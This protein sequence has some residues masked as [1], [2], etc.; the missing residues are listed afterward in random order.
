MIKVFLAEDEFIVREGI[1]KNIDWASHGYD[2]CG[3]ASD[4]ELALPM[5]RKLSPDIVITDI[6]MPF[7]DGLE[8]SRLIRK[9]F[10]WIEIIILS[11]Y[12]EFEYAKEGIKIGV[13]QYLTKPITGEELL[14]EVD[15]V[16]K[17]IVARKEEEALKEQFER[18]MAENDK[19]DQ[20][21]LFHNI[22]SG[23][24]STTD[25]LAM[26]EKL[27]IDLFAMWY[28]I[29]L[30][31]AKSDNHEIDEYSNSSVDISKRI[32]EI[33][34]ENGCLLFDRNLEGAAIV[35]KADSVEELISKQ[36]TVISSIEAVLS[37]YSQVRYFGGIGQPV[38]RLSSIR[39][40]FEDARYAM[41][42]RYFVTDNRFISGEDA[43]NVSS[44][45]TD[46]NLNMKEIDAKRID[47]RNL[48]KFFKTG[49]VDEAPFFLSEFLKSAGDNAIKSGIFRQYI[50]MDAYFC[51]ITFV[52]ELGKS[53]NDIDIPEVD[54]DILASVDST[55]KYMQNI[56]EKVIGVRESI[57]NSRYS[58]IVE[59]AIRYIEDNYS[60]DELSLNMLASHVNVSPNHL[61]TIFSQQ[62]GQTFI[63]Y[64]TEYRME[65]AKELLKCTNMRS[66]EIS[67]E[68]GY[69]DPHY[70]SY[71][72]KK[73]VGMTPTKYRGGKDSEDEE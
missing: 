12:E 15:A 13:A 19:K 51:A 32:K 7:M 56:F 20:R 11:G 29:V 9:E 25:L 36:E 47:R 26:A 50:A 34:D 52:E 61:S 57:A 37:E 24:Y 10:P 21:E 40:S 64:L 27:D 33:I 17:R 63:K 14:A 4:G 43:I 22:V 35:F 38:N 55:I 68:V 62:T 23:G 70:F 46:D 72:F 54:T 69:K 18:E 41:A 67:E 49:S 66:S 3:E 30:L 44:S 5:I 58:E 73:S 28:S 48:V 71:M 2:F 59:A 1:K 31:Y 39:S 65:K 42:H 16:A 6:K 60:D 53:R 8:L 45:N